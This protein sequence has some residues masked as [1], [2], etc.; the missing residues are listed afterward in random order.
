VFAFRLGTGYLHEEELNRNW[1]VVAAPP[2]IVFREPR[3][4]YD[5]DAE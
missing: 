5:L 1:I 2:A 3:D 4:E